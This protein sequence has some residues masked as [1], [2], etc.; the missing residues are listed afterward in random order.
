MKSQEG[1]D[2]FVALIVGENLGVTVKVIDAQRFVI[3]CHPAHQAPFLERKSSV[4][5][6]VLAQT[7]KRSQGKVFAAVIPEKQRCCVCIQTITQQSSDVVE[8]SIN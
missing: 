1:L 7:M 6:D 8:L 3:L 2:V 4:G 5:V